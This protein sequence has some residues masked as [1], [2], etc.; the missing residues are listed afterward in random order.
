MEFYRLPVIVD[1]SSGCDAGTY[2]NV[3]R[4]M[5]YQ[6]IV[7]W[8]ENNLHNTSYKVGVDIIGVKFDTKNNNI[9]IDFIL[10][11]NTSGP[12]DV[13][14]ALSNPSYE[15]VQIDNLKYSVIGEPIVYL[16]EFHQGN[17]IRYPF[18]F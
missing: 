1:L 8:Y 3:H 13:I 17:I 15:L 5:P 6:L 4:D 12:K 11:E 10:K 16:V 18:S 7:E 2:K 9:V 14:N